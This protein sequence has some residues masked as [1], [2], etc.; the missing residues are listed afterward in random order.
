M[1]AKGGGTNNVNVTLCFHTVSSV[2]VDGLIGS[3]FIAHLW[4]L[5]TEVRRDRELVGEPAK[6]KISKQRLSSVSIPKNLIVFHVVCTPTGWKLWR[7]ILVIC[8]VNEVHECTE[9]VYMKYR[10]PG[11]VN[12]TLWQSST[13]LYLKT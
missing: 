13:V 5:A 4:S 6:V 1:R 7:F 12:V 8:G 11:C 2:C 10:T 9:A 3:S